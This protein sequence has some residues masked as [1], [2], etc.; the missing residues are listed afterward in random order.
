MPGYLKIGMTSRAPEERARELS[1]GTG[2]AVP[3]V[4]A[5]AGLVAHK[6]GWDEEVPRYAH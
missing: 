4:V 5:F 3:Y 1:Q 6:V 2:V